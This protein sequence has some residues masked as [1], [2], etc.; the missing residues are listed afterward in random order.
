MADREDF[1]LGGIDV[2]TASFNMPEA[3]LGLAKLVLLFL[4]SLIAFAFLTSFLPDQYVT[5]RSTKLSENIYQ[6]IVPMVSMIIGYY[7]AKD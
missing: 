2:G 4:F 7:F 3:K 1:E 6:S 5:D